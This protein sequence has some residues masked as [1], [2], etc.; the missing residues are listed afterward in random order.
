MTVT[1]QEKVASYVELTSAALEDANTKLAAHAAAADTYA[2]KV[3]TAVD[4]LVKH[5]FLKESNRARAIRELQS[6]EFA[7]DQLVK[8]ALAQPVEVGSSLG[9]AVSPAGQVKTSNARNRRQHD[10]DF[11]TSLGLTAEYA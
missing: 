11:V 1:F 3:N 5:G 10:I 9:T 6:P 8:V 4:N 7:I 2:A